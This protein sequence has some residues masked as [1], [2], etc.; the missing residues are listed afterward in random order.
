[1]SDQYQEF[2][3]AGAEVLAVANA[4]EEHAS[5]YAQRLNLPFPCLVDSEH[6]VFDLYQV[7]SSIVS[8]GQRPG[9]YVIDRRGVVKYA[10]I[11]WQQWEIPSNAEILGI[12]RQLALT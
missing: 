10:Q 7:E 2:R 5:P 8:L 1:M 11:G 6:A 4:N 3:S 9:L 12:C